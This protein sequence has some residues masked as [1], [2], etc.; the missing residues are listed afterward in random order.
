MYTHE[1]T[2]HEVMTNSWT[3]Q[4]WNSNYNSYQL[5]VTINSSVH[6]T[7]IMKCFRHFLCLLGF[8]NILVCV[9]A[10]V[11]KNIA[12]LKWI[13][14]S[15]DRKCW[16]SSVSRWLVGGGG[17]FKVTDVMSNIKASWSGIWGRRETK[18]AFLKYIF[19]FKN[20]ILTIFFHVSC[21][22]CSNWM[23]KTAGLY[24][25][26]SCCLCPLGNKRE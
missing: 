18:E 5:V 8:V 10:D 15:T 24:H 23:K 21:F 2:L 22:K 6:F 3:K 26:G 17:V 11:L 9:C 1:G 13:Q 16:S 7:I 20:I 4:N 25:T 12:T 19:F 14:G